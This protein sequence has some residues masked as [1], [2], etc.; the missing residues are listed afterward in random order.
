MGVMKLVGMGGGG[1]VMTV[2]QLQSWLR[3]I[4]TGCRKNVFRGG[5]Q[6]VG[7]YLRRDHAKQLRRH[8]DPD[9]RPWLPTYAQPRPKVGQVVPMVVSRGPLP[10]I[11]PRDKLPSARTGRYP[12]VITAKIT[13]ADGKKRAVAFRQR[14]GP[15]FKPEKALVRTAGKRKAKRILQYLTRPGRS[16]RI[17][18]SGLDYGYTRGTRWIEA[19]HAGGRYREGAS[20]GVFR[21]VIRMFRGAAR[22][23]ARPIVGWSAARIGYVENYL[24]DRFVQYA[25]TVQP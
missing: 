5:L 4:Q 2:P 19:L 16:V 6:H 17:S 15:P 20:R 3:K 21:S 18:D 9:G 13:N 11:G 24:A 12:S 7:K 14:Y 1:S 10:S 23:P 8:V 25:Q 22:V